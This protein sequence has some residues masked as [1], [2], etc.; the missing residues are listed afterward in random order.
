MTLL[1]LYH[2]IAFILTVLYF[3]LESSPCL[4]GNV[5]YE[6]WSNNQISSTS[7]LSK[8]LGDQQKFRFSLRWRILSFPL[9]IVPKLR[10]CR[11]KQ[12][13]GRHRKRQII[14]VGIYSRNMYIASLKCLHPIRW[15]GEA[16]R[17]QVEFRLYIADSPVQLRNPNSFF[18]SPDCVQPET[19]DFET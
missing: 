6:L 1:L 13:S 14:L 5:P 9:N 3:V 2:L 15:E 12:P 18:I 11:R 16:A 7:L 4:G 8:R 10:C 17:S 19:V